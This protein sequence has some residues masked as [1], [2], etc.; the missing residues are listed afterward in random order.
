MPQNT[1]IY[2]HISTCPHS[3]P[4]PHTGTG[5]CET[6]TRSAQGSA[7][8]RN[9]TGEIAEAYTGN[10]QLHKYKRVGSK[11]QRESE[12]ESESESE[13]C[14]TANLV[15]ASAPGHFNRVHS[16]PEK[17]HLFAENPLD[18]L[19]PLLIVVTLV[20]SGWMH[21]WMHGWMTIVPYNM[22]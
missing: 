1:K 11:V 14:A 12:S 20:N 6:C 3:L 18:V 2:T 21:G 7:P 13:R 16:G 8:T 22:R 15:N 4:R 9:S 17:I 5:R 10:A 19:E